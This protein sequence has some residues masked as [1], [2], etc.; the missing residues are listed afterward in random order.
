MSEETM[1]GRVCGK[2]DTVIYLDS[3]ACEPDE[4][5]QRDRERVRAEVT[6]CLLKLGLVPA[7][8][9]RERS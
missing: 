4:A 3:C 6:R 7:S 2:C 5:E 1:D 9:V 8:L